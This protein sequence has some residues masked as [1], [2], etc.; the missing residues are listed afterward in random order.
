MSPEEFMR[1]PAVERVTLILNDGR[2]LMDRIYL[3]YLIR[4]YK[5]FDFYIE[6]WY[7]PASNKIDKILI[8]E[9]DDVMHLYEKNIDISDI[10]NT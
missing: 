1:L 2:E 7:L 9:L 10:F 6:L 3:Y 8:F 5:I 4:L